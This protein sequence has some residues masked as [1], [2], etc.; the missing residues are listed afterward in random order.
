M[1]NASA[2]TEET[3][4]ARAPRDAAQVQRYLRLLDLNAEWFTFQLF[5]DQENKPSPD[6]L[7]K[8]LTVDKVRR[9]VLDPY[10]QG[11]AGVWVTVNDTNGRG[12]KAADV[13]RVRAV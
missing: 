13:T 6:P 4:S 5:T 1:F 12:R 11:H 2:G 10:E 8:V 3:V 7:A 9:S